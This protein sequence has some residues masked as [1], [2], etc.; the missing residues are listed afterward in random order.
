M[1]A[2][3]A[4]GPM[5]KH[6]KNAFILLLAVFALL[7][8]LASFTGA[9]PL[10]E[11][12]NPLFFTL[13][14]LFSIGSIIVWLFSWANLIKKSSGVSG[15]KLTITGFCCVFASLTPVQLGAEALRSIRAK[16]QFNVPYKESI[17][18]SM[19][20]KG[21]KFLAIAVV[22]AFSFAGF[23][24]NPLLGGWIKLGLAS[25]FA[26]ILAAALLFLLPMNYRFGIAI[27]RGFS[28]LSRFGGFF[29]KLADYFQGYAGYFKKTSAKTIAFT[30][31]LGFASLLLEFAALVFCFLAVD[32]PLPLYS[33][34][35]LFV[36][37]SILERTP[38]LPRG[39]GIIEAAGFAFLNTPEFSGA[40]LSAPQIGAAIIVFDAVRLV[41]PT[42]AS[43]AI[44]LAVFSKRRN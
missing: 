12:A 2:R 42:I 19:V 23:L 35:A 5:E 41:I 31:L 16:D 15:R 3:L 32:V 33:A 39:I 25:G 43:L 29:K 17:A 37:V 14:A 34:A 44:S 1:P 26:V 11:S 9:F 24:Y 10:I 4:D 7:A 40:A 22:S 38:V 8:A 36:L 28:A 6:L 13:A 20:V 21:I 18:A 27:S 30:A